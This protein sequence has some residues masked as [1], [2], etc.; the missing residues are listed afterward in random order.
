MLHRT[1]DNVT[2]EKSPLSCDL[3]NL[4]YF[5]S[6]ICGK[7]ALIPENALTELDHICYSESAEPVI[8]RNLLAVQRIPKG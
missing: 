7:W 2:S 6:V 5:A 1:M 3:D 8:P 4:F